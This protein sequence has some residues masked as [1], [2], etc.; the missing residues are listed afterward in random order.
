MPAV[1]C[2][3]MTLRKMLLYSITQINLQ[4]GVV[5][6]SLASTMMPDLTKN[7]CTFGCD[8]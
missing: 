8:H 5:K 2:L 6:T 1:A 4:E 3:P 7:I